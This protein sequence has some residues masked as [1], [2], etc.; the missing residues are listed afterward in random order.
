MATLF[1]LTCAVLANTIVTSV[2]ALPQSFL[3]SKLRKYEVHPLDVSGIHNRVLD[4]SAY[5]RP[6]RMIIRPDL[7]MH[8]ESDH[9]TNV[10]N[11]LYFTGH[12]QGHEYDPVHFLRLNLINQRQGIQGI[13]ELQA[14]EGRN[15]YETYFFDTLDSHPSGQP[16]YVIYRDQDH[17]DRIDAPA[18][19]GHLKRILRRR[20]L[21]ARQADGSPGAGAGGGTCKIGLV[22]D[23]SF[24]QTL[25][26]P[27]GAQAHE[28]MVGAVNGIT[29]L[30]ERTF[31]VKLV[32]IK[33]V[34]DNSDVLGLQ[35]MGLNSQGTAESQITLFTAKQAS[36]NLNTQESCANILFTFRNMG[37]ALGVAALGTVQGGGICDPKTQVSVFTFRDVKTNQPRVSS[38]ILNTIA[39]EL[40]HSFGSMHDEQY[41]ECKATARQW[42]MAAVVSQS[43]TFSECSIKAI[44]EKMAR[45]ACL[46]S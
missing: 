36:V 31:G 14:P 8:E 7:D 21:E 26:G 38:E 16:H 20:R 40:G 37:V 10:T 29:G 5:G 32:P 25:G 1:W 11:P 24:A 13:F 39:H 34:V 22:A 18:D 12:L 33:T 6:L 30:Y 44:R 35:D 41:P 9:G 43:T 45:A 23:S 46:R 4:I 3:D 28:L 2:W 15:L 19:Q 17:H 42:I 27:D